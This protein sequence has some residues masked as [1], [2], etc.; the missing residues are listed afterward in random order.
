MNFC[1]QYLFIY[2]F[3]GLIKKVSFISMMEVYFYLILIIS[4]GLEFKL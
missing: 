1:L 4:F 3:I 2:Y